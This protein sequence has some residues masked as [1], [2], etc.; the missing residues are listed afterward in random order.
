MLAFGFPT[1]TFTMSLRNALKAVLKNRYLVYDNM[2]LFLRLEYGIHTTKEEL[3]R[4]FHPSRPTKVRPEKRPLSE[5]YIQRYG[6][7]EEVMFSPP[8]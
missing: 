5:E 3:Y 1:G 7:N 2:V 8:L 4:Y 6:L